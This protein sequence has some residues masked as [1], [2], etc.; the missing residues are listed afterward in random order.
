[1]STRVCTRCAQAKP[2]E[3][4]TRR[5]NG[6]LVG[7]CKAC[8]ADLARAFRAGVRAV[9]PRKHMDWT[10]PPT[11]MPCL[12]CGEVMPLDAFPRIHGTSTEQRR[13]WC[14]PCDAALQR[15]KRAAKRPPI[16]VKP[17]TE[18]DL[19]AARVFLIRPTSRDSALAEAGI[20]ASLYATALRAMAVA[21]SRVTEEDYA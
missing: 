10:S 13:R 14:R 17:A 4:Y 11:E 12:K 21:G 20:A 18:A 15:L 19:L 2:P 1:M 5:R 9:T 3:D 8:S 16:A 7:R 6:A